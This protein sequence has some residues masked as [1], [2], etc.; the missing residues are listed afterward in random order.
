MIVAWEDYRDLPDYY[1]FVTP[2]NANIY[3]QR[4]RGVG[5]LGNADVP[6]VV[7]GMSP[8]YGTV[9]ISITLRGSDFSPIASEN[10]VHFGGARASV[11]ASTDSTLQVFTPLAATHALP[12]VTFEG[13]TGYGQKPFVSTPPSSH[14]LND[15]SFGPSLGIETGSY[16]WSVEAGDLNSDGKQD[17]VIAVYDRNIV[18][19]VRNAGKMGAEQPVSF[20]APIE[21]PVQ[22]QPTGVEIADLDSDGKLDIAVACEGNNTVCVLR[23][24]S[25]GDTLRFAPAVLF[26][27]GPN[28]KGIA[29]SDLDGDGRP[30]IITPDGGGG[31][32]SVLAGRFDS[33]GIT[34]TSFARAI[35]FGAG[36]K[37]ISVVVRDFDGDLRPDIGVA[38]S[39]A[40]SVAVLRNTSSPGNIDLA[41]P[42]FTFYPCGGV[43]GR[44]ASGDL[45]RDGKA[46]IAVGLTDGSSVV[47][48]RN[49]GTSGTIA[50]GPKVTV[51]AGD[52]VWCIALADFTGDARLD[53][54]TTNYRDGTISLLENNSTPGSLGDPFTFR[55]AITIPVGGNPLHAVVS[56]LN[57]DGLAD[58]V[59]ADRTGEEVRVMNGREFSAAP[60]KITSFSPSTAYSG[61]Q[62]T[63][64]GSGFSSRASENKVRIG[65]TPVAYIAAAEPTRL[66]VRMPPGTSTGLIR[67]TTNGRTAFSAAPLQVRFKTGGM[68]DSSAFTPP[69][70]LASL[71][72]PGYIGF[73]DCDDDGRPEMLQA[74]ENSVHSTPFFT[75]VSLL[76]NESGNRTLLFQGVP[77]PYHVVMYT[78]PVKPTFVWHDVD[79]DGIDDVFFPS[80]YN[81]RIM[82][83]T[84]IQGWW[85]P[86]GQV[87]LHSLM[88]VSAYYG[89]HYETGFLVDGLDGDGK[90]DLLSSSQFHRKNL[91][92]R[93]CTVSAR[94]GRLI[95]PRR[96]WEPDRFA[97]RIRGFRW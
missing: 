66:T 38:C 28:P 60:P 83:N 20:D 71:G 15:S 9:G 19:V 48:F 10:V 25:A 72:R 31:T 91:I 34:D 88:Q 6:P 79:G 14:T 40:Y 47:L 50:F 8:T 23:N 29:I 82:R 44:M 33:W 85:D 76:A 67:V 63:I 81:A 21:L 97:G 56:D 93:N 59:L 36:A 69:T 95:H 64:N 35:Q 32:I 73:N 12:A 65:Q 3:A 11:T 62:L 53:I 37:P 70:T 84:S 55:P 58:I 54:V 4:V 16:P 22:K 39:A 1:F 51:G 2:S 24:I 46:D 17:L 74:R 30:D 68:L 13:L 43:P 77:F 45:D 89:G 27:V 5:R 92:L 75:P 80:E 90:P 78:D 42:A 61:D 52:G 87:H 49:V 94:F 26:P 57:G 86:P 7:T 18:A 96:R 41:S